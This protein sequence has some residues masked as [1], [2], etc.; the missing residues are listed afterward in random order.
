MLAI[1]RRSLAITLASPALAQDPWPARPIRC[2]VPFPPGGGTDIA[3]RLATRRLGEAL[4]TPIVVENRPGAGGTIGSLAVARAAPDGYTIGIATTSTHPV[5]PIFQRDLPYDPVADFSAITQ[6]GSTP[7]VLIGGR[8]APATDLAGLLEWLRSRPGQVNYA[9]VGITTL[10]YLL[11]RQ[12]EQLAGLSLSHVPYRGS[13]QVYPDLL[14]GTVALLLDNPPASS[15]MVREGQL[16]A[17]A[18]TQRSNL[19]PAVPSFASQGVAGF[20]ASFW[21]GLLAPPGTPPAY[22]ARMRD[23]LAAQILTDAGRAEFRA[24][25]IEPIISAP[26]EF[27]AAIAADAASWRAL[28]TRL[29]IKPE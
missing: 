1:P 23:A 24:S 21:Y 5:A 11:T 4:G 13:S 10:G 6:L 27:A 16:K 26:Q 2:V 3:A 20:D 9:S 15:A 12:F 17:Y 18:V 22:L 14:N 25:D 8:A 19:I 29:D 7:Y 28:A